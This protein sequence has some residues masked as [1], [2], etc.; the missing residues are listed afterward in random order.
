MPA[1]DAVL[2]DR[3]TYDGL[4]DWLDHVESFG[5]LARFSG[6]HWD[7]EMGAITE[8]MVREYAEQAPALLFDDVPGYDAGYRCLY[9]TLNSPRR[10]AL[11]LGMAPEG[12]D[13]MPAYLHT[14]RERTDNLERI[15]REEVDDGPILEHTMEGDDVDLTAFPVPVHH[16]LDGG[17][18]IGTAD[19]VITRDPDDGWVNFG[20]Y[21]TQVRDE[22]TALSYISPGKDGRLHRDAYL[23]RGEKCPTIIVCGQDPAVWLASTLS[24]PSGV[25]EYEYAG[26]LK[27]RPI[28]VV[29]GDVTGLPMPADAEIALEGY[30][31]EATD[32]EGPFGEWPGY[33]AGGKRLEHVFE[34][35][36]IYHRD[37]PILTC[38][39][40]NKPP[41]EHLFERCVSRSSRLWE[42]LEGAG[43]PGIEG[44]WV[45]EVGEGRTFQVVALNQRYA[46]HAKQAG[47]LVQH[48]TP[49]R[50]AGRWSVVVDADIEPTDLDEVLWAMCTRVDPAQDLE[51]MERTW[52]SKIDPMTLG[53]DPGDDAWFNSRVVV[54][55]T[56]PYEHRDDF[57]PVA[58]TS[59]ELREEVLTTWGERIREAAAGIE[60]AIGH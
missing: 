47:V 10:L 12:Y 11:T 52:T 45:H 53:Q 2:D 15:P 18:Y 22:T 39:A 35:E 16:E 4:R 48:V 34:V 31:T 42:E 44:V 30:L 28:E 32:W 19:I 23:D 13:S 8:I 24:V 5:E 1:E 37:D 33:Y 7:R 27:G 58:E 6:A 60:P 17:R 38:S 56:I 54:D 40:S 9:A 29:H 25:S 50:Y 36:K 46:G 55:A 20:T 49:A 51:V 41:H 43:V 3:Q 26:G 21:R 57:P 59:D 14:Y